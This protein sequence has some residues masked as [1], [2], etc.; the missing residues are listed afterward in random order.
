MADPFYTLEINEKL[1]L[2]FLVKINLSQFSFITALFYFLSDT[3]PFHRK[4]TTYKLYIVKLE[5]GLAVSTFLKNEKREDF[6]S[7]TY[8]ISDSLDTS[9]FLSFSFN[10]FFFDF[11]L[12][13]ILLLCLTRGIKHRS[14]GKCQ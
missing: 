1:N 4:R 8:L 12:K 6:K 7:S 13:V 11:R 3:F 5:K 2:I 10:L 14:A 9:H